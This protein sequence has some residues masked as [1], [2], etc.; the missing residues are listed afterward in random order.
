MVAVFRL[1]EV[2]CDTSGEITAVIWGRSVKVQP[3]QAPPLTPSSR[4]YKYVRH[5][6]VGPALAAGQV[7]VGR[8]VYLK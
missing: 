8:G 1:Q 2:V 6:L 3:G 5:D 7:Q 4:Y